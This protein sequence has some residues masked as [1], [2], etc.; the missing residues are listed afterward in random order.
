MDSDI[1]W[2]GSSD[3]CDTGFWVS[4]NLAKEMLC[5]LFIIFLISRI[6]AQPGTQIILR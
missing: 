3:F 6:K 2:L 1:I 5:S 4:L